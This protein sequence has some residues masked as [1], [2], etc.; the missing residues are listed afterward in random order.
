MALILLGCEESQEVCKA[1][2]SRGHEA[3]SN[4][5]IDCSGGHPEW[6]IKSDVRDAIK[7]K[8]WDMAIFFTPCTFSTL[9]GVRWMYNPDG[10]INSDRLKGLKE[11]A[12]LLRDCLNS[13]VPL[14]ACENPI[15]HRYA[16]EVIGR[17]YDQIIQPW[18]FGHGETK[19][20]CL[21]LKNLPK[22]IPTNI[23]SGREQRIAK[24]PPTP[25]RAKLRSKTFPGIADAFADQWGNLLPLTQ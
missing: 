10:S 14:V 8:P 23:V 11:Y 3:Y 6:H 15:P 16:V 17:K 13:D 21:W 2:R 20:T 9:S 12:G 1:F 7:M 4:D 18:M 5:I 25:D 22:I 19:A 24:L